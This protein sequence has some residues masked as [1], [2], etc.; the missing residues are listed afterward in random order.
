MSPERRVLTDE[1]RK[2][3]AG[4]WTE[5]DLPAAFSCIV[6]PKRPLLAAGSRNVMAM[7][8]TDVEAKCEVCTHRCMISTKDRTTILRNPSIAIV[9]WDCIQ[10]WQARCL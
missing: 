3:L 9:C 10:E 4:Q 7:R 5:A 1:V 8:P 6:D 2:R